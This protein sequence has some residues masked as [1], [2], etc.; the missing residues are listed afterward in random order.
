[1]ASAVSAVGLS[2]DASGKAETDLAQRSLRLAWP[3]LS[4][5]LEAVTDLA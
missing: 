3:F 5:E 2:R 1:M 4:S